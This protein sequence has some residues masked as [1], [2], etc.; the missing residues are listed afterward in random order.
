MGK[1]DEKKI[2]KRAHKATDDENKH[3]ASDGENKHKN[4][5]SFDTLGSRPFETNFENNDGGFYQSKW[6]VQFRQLCEYKVQFGH[7]LVPNKYAANPKLGLWVSTQ[8]TTYRLHQ[9]GKP[10]TMTAER[11][12]ALESVGFDWGKSSTLWSEQ[13]EQLVE[14]KVQFGH[15]LVPQQYAASPKLGK[16]VSTQ[17][18]TYRLQREGKPSTMTEERIRE[19]ESIGFDSGTTKTDLESP[20]CSV[21]FQ[22]LCEFKAQLGHKL[23]QLAHVASLTRQNKKC[24]SQN[25]EYS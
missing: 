21:Q 17:R 2:K 6:R 11:I 3:K 9:E 23:Q 8:R 12:R 14:Y 16:W 7:C 22:Q 24:I 15:C 19:L 18:T 13:F 25:P 4:K 20:I 1:S 5:P 10:S